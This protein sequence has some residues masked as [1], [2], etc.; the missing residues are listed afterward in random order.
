M[1]GAE[2]PAAEIVSI[3][4]SKAEALP[5]VKAVWTTDAKTVRFAGRMWRP[6]PR[7][8]RRSR[9]DAARLVKV[10]YKEKPFTPEL[11]DAMRPDAPL[12]FTDARARRA[13]TSA[14]GQRGRP[15]GRPTRRAAAGTSTRASR[16]RRSCT[17][18][19][20]T[21]PVH[22]HSCL[23][24]HGVVAS[25]EGEQPHR[26]RLDP[27]HLRRARSLAE[28]LRIDRKNVRVLCEH[29]GGGLR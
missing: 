20:T 19:R 28:A 6:W 5:G 2:L 14:Q 22:T 4:T 12:V 10:A 3:D 13:R 11:R 15:R 17:K 29:M 21:L 23:E 8:R 1:I 18:R 26:L 25:W 24:T 27:G 7:S 16:K 9:I